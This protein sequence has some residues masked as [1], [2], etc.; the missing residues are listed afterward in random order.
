MTSKREVYMSVVGAM[1]WLANV[2]R[3]ELSY[4]AAQLARFVSNPARIHYDAAMRVL[5]YLAKSPDR[6]LVF[7]PDPKLPL[8]LYADSDWSASFSVSG[9]VAYF[10]GCPV[11]WASKTQTSVSLSSAESE[12]FG[13]MMAA[14]DG[15]FLRD[16][17]DELGLM[18]AGPT[19]LYLDS[20]SAIDLAFD[21][22][23]FRRTKHIMRATHYLRDLVARRFFVPR[24]I[25]GTSNPA[26][27]FTK[28]LSRAAFVAVVRLLAEPPRP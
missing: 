19:V 26:D 28:A 6:E 22:V 17:L 27:V 8:T 20:K 9:W 10:Y 12:I 3:P 5:A 15:V 14:R 13:A 21:P 4:A 25:A 7:S 23:A 18:Q 2:T 11:A 24:H 1:L 16:L